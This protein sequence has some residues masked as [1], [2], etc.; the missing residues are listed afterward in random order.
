LQNNDPW[1][2]DKK[3][4]KRSFEMEIT[5]NQGFEDLNKKL[6]DKEN[7]K[8]MTLWEKYQIKKK[9]RK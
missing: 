2:Y 6:I 1:G 8:D 5:F 9:E 7:Q 4:R 3:N